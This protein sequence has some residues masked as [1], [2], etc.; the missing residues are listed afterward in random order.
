[1]KKFLII[2]VCLFLIGCSGTISN[3]EIKKAQ[4]FCSDKGGLDVIDTR[5]VPTFKCND[6]IIWHRI[7]DAYKSNNEK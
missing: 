3:N 5:L 2:V 4:D 1:M 7:E 6:E